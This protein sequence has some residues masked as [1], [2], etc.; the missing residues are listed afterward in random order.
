MRNG[1]YAL[2]LAA[3]CSASTPTATTAP[4]RD[5][6]SSTS[7]AAVQAA[8][9]AAVDGPA[10]TEED[11]ARDI[12]RHPAETLAFFGVAPGMDVIELAPGGGW[13]TRILAPLLRGNGTLAV[14]L[15]DGRYGD[16]FRQL[17]S[18]DPAL[19]GDVRVAR[20]QPPDGIELGEPESADVVLTFRNTHGWAEAGAERAVY[21]AVFR[22]LRPGGTFGVV[23][24]R[25]AEGAEL[26]AASGYLPEAYVIRVA[27]QA[28]FELVDRSEINAN[29]RDTRDHEH[30]VWSLPPVLRGGD[31]DRERFLAIGESDRMTLRFR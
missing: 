12:Y 8:L 26:D 5:D 23:Q 2:L 7:P 9:R 20:L 27:E 18:D 15:P 28:G 14:A 1:I 31:V 6:A 16:M 3:G 13:Y 21:D 30:G 24:H 25:D 11:R 4:L 10:R 29:P 17:Q 19:Y 22:V